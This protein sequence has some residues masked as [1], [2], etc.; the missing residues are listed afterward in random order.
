MQDIEN[1][2]HLR[3]YYDAKQEKFVYLFPDWIKTSKDI[4]IFDFVLF[5]IVKKLNETKI[6]LFGKF[7]FIK[8]VK[9]NEAKQRVKIFGINICKINVK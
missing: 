5:E 6:L 3:H 4:K 9:L 7:D 8:F 2:G 1:F